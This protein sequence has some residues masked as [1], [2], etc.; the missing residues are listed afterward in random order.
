MSDLQA[1]LKRPGTKVSAREVPGV[2]AKAASRE[3]LGAYGRV[4]LESRV[5]TASPHELVLM[6][7]N[8]L[9]K[10]LKEIALAIEADEKVKRLRATESALAIVDGLD[11]TLDRERGGS[12]AE[13]LHLVYVCLLERLLAGTLTGIAEAHRSVED[14]RDAWMEMAGAG[15][16]R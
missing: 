14:L 2:V 7:Y 3:A 13:S 4:S 11:A 5:A 1:L 6:L 10:R 8:Q 12:V 16:T 9:L 15:A